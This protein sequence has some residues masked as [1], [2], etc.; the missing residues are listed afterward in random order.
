MN[1]EEQPRVER[2]PIYALDLMFKLMNRTLEDR[3]IEKREVT[4]V[5]RSF[6]H[7]M[8]YEKIALSRYIHGNF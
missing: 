2:R 7:L 8:S 1:G 3:Q 6:A 5:S 4:D